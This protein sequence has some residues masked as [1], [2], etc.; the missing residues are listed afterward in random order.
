M[1]WLYYPSYYQNWAVFWNYFLLYIICILV[2]RKCSL[3]DTLSI[4][5]VSLLKR[6]KQY[7]WSICHWFF[8]KLIQAQILPKEVVWKTQPHFLSAIKM[9]EKKMTLQ[10]YQVTWMMI[11]KGGHWNWISFSTTICS[12]HLKGVKKLIV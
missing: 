7:D 2:P 4:E 10:S 5:Q 11:L 3:Y 1:H 6:S 8:F 12:L 9:E